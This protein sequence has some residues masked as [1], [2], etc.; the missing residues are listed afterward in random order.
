[1]T[2]Q[3][4]PSIVEVHNA[5][6]ARAAELKR[7]VLASIAVPETTVAPD[8]NFEQEL[9]KNPEQAAALMVDIPFDAYESFLAEKL[10]GSLRLTAIARRTSRRRT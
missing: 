7:R 10:L 9:A 1:M 4:T 3:T 8:E 5:R 2:E 6:V